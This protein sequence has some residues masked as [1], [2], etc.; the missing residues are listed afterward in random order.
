MSAAE[1]RELL[2]QGRLLEAERL[3]ERV[4]ESAPDDVEALNMVALGELRKGA[5]P[6]ALGLLERA[7]RAQ[8]DDALTQ[9]NLGRVKET[10]GD[11]VG[12][13]SAYGS[14]VRLRPEFFVAR[15]HLAHALDRGK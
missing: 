10:L 7:E 5:A 8:P 3:F 6:R 12:A 11:L 9:Y 4:L 15:L 13:V 2:R 1:A 14:A